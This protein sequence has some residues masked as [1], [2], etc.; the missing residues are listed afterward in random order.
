MPQ[1]V[2]AVDGATVVD[3]PWATAEV[4]VSALNSAASVL[5][6]QLESRAAIAGSLD[7]WWGGA[8]D[9]FDEKYLALTQTASGLVE[10]LAGRAGAIADGATAANDEQIRRNS[11]VTN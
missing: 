11:A 7:G 4:A 5:G 9:D 2:Q 6:A 8:R 3:F 1:R 10:S